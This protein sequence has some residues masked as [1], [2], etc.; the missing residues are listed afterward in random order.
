MALDMVRAVRQRDADAEAS[1]VVLSEDVD[2][3]RDDVV[4]RHAA[5]IDQLVTNV[6]YG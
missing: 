6:V 4:E 2:T 3:W 1:P 5:E